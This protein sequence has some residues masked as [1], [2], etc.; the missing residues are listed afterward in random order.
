MGIQ[1]S[2]DK[3]AFFAWMKGWKQ[4][5]IRDS[6][7]TELRDQNGQR[8]FADL[9]ITIIFFIQFLIMRLKIKYKVGELLEVVIVLELV[10][11]IKGKTDPVHIDRIIRKWRGT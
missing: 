5:K 10:L 6:K 3:G 2:L 4:L 7:T 11:V 1:I 9:F 8:V